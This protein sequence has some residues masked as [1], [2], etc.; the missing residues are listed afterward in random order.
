MWFWRRLFFS[1]SVLTVSF[2]LGLGLGLEPLWTRTWLGLEPLWTWTWLG[3]EPLWTWTCLGLD[4]GGL[5][6]SP[7]STSTPWSWAIWVFTVV[8][9]EELRIEDVMTS[10]PGTLLRTVVLPVY[11]VFQPGTP[12]LRVKDGPDLIDVSSSWEDEV[13]LCHQI[14]WGKTKVQSKVWGEKHGKMVRY[15]IEEEGWACW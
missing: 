13:P 8:L 12:L 14:L 11:E 1:F 3:L 4:K 7:R 9:C 2:G 6:Y 15:D 10:D 5:D